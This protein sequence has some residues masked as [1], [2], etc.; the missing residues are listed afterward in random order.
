[1]DPQQS[2]SMMSA[3]VLSAEEMT[4]RQRKLDDRDT[5]LLT[6]LTIL[7]A[8]TVPFCF[9]L[10]FQ[11]SHYKNGQSGLVASQSSE[12]DECIEGEAPSRCQ[13]GAICQSGACVVPGAPARCERGAMCDDGCTCEQPLVCDDRKVCTLPLDPGVCDDDSVLDF[14]KLLK[15]KCGDAKTCESKD[16]DKYAVS[17]GDFLTLMTQFPNTLAVHFADG[18]PDPEAESPWQGLVKDSPQNKHYL[19][20]LRLNIDEFKAADRIIMVGLAS[21]DR[22]RKKDPKVDANQA[23]TLQRL[24]ST[25]RLIHLAATSTLDPKDADAIDAKVQF[26]KLGDER[27]IDADFYRTRYGNRPI[28]L[29]EGTENELRRLVEVDEQSASKDELRWRDRTLN[30]VVFIIPIH[31]KLPG[32]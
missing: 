24:I 23:I 11:V 30:Q 14:L 27:P 25:Q 17:R 32:A 9:V 10:A 20:R 19:N 15:E 4:V 5:R 3:P 29:D 1:M 7:S 22:K 6:V 18:D 16:L 2:P 13:A 31:C 8:I 21:R 12:F 26:I 28:A